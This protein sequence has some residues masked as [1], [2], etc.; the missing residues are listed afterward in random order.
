MKI[1]SNFPKKTWVIFSVITVTTTILFAKCDSLSD[2]ND[3][4]GFPFPFYEYI[5]GKRSVEPENRSSFNSIYLLFDLIIYC[6]LA[7]FFTFL[8]QRSKK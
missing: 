5:G 7:Y 6:G 8:I 4:L 3:R 2:G 1:V